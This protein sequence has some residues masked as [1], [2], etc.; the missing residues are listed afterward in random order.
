MG[1]I[2]RCVCV[3]VYVCERCHIIVSNMMIKMLGKNINFLL[4]AA[5]AGAKV[6]RVYNMQHVI[7]PSI[8]VTIK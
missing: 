3:C 5:S 7:N 4:A 8:S 2:I 1:I 6:E